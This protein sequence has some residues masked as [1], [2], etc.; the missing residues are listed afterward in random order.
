MLIAV[1]GV[2]G[3]VG[4]YLCEYLLRRGHEVVGFSRNPGA[5]A[6]R[7]H[8]WLSNSPS[9]DPQHEFV[10]ESNLSWVAGR[11]GDQASVQRLLQSADA[12]IHSA[13]SRDKRS[14]MDTP[15]DPLKIYQANVLG[16]HQLLHA[17]AAAGVRRF[18]FLSSG[19]VHQRVLPDRVLDETHPLLP[20]SIYGA[21]KAA[22][23]TLVCAY[24]GTQN[25]QTA[26][27]RPTGIYGITDPITD[28]RWYALIR[29][30]VEGR[31][32]DIGSGAKLVH[33]A[34][35]ASAACLLVES[36]Q[37]PGGD[38][39]NCCDQFIANATVAEIAKEIT[40]SKSEFTG[41]RKP[42]GNAMVTQRIQQWGMQFGGHNK[43]RRT[44]QTIVQH[45]NPAHR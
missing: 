27:L 21:H 4:R 30:I 37:S 17:A 24:H 5:D 18:V 25:L 11:L 9:R 26:N 16:C 23:E 36:P 31:S 39:F 20:G 44:I 43:L 32:V 8:Q 7:L 38:T 10:N 12:V 35:V 22:S 42:A 28:S 40:N 33:A 13:V 34:D 29:D 14:F 2:G 45:L 1:T 41:M 3:F 15:S 19:A 6:N